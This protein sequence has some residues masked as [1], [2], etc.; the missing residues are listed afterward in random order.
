MSKPFSNGLHETFDFTIA[1]CLIAAAT[2]WLRGG[3]YVHGAE[4][5]RAVPSVASVEGEMILADG[6]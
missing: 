3:K 2:S 1:T 4:D 6:D 5:E